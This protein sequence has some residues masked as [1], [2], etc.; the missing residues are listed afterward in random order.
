MKKIKYFF[1]ILQIAI[2]FSICKSQFILQPAFPGLVDFS[3]PVELVNAYDGTDR[4]FLVQQHGKIYVFSNSPSVST[5]KNFINLTSKVSQG[6]LS[7]LF[8]LAFHPD[9][10]NKRYFYVY[11]I[12]DSTATQTSKWLRVS[13]YTASSS[14]PDTALVSSELILLTEPVIGAGYHFGGKIAFGP[15]GYLYATCGDGPPN[16]GPSPAQDKT[17]LLGKIFRINVD[18]ASAG[19]SYSIPATNPFYGNTQGYREEIYAYGFRNL[20]KF[21][22]DYTTNNLWGGDVGQNLY[23]EIDLIENGKNYGWDKMEGFHCVPVYLCDTAGYGFTLPVYEYRHTGGQFAVM[24]GYVYR[25]SQ[26]PDLYG[27]YIYGDEISSKIWALTY[28][29]INPPANIQLLDTT[30]DLVSFGVDQNE[31]IYVLS[32]SATAG[33]IYKLVNNSIIT[34]SLRTAIEGFYNTENNQLNIRDTLNIYLRSSASPYS[35]I[36]S[37]KTVI[38]SLTNTGLCFFRNAP[39]GKYYLAINHRNTLETWSRIGGDSLRKGDIMSYDFTAD[40]ST[41]YG[42]NQVRKGNI[43][44]IYSGDINKDGIIDIVDQSL[45]ENDAFNY[46]SGYIATDLNGDGSADLTDQT[47]LDNNLYNF[48]VKITP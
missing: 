21:S 30:F 12:F 39:N 44:C 20:W 46:N 41:A 13:R 8:G 47:I 11:Y 42:N 38:D 34:L 7:G 28:N 35:I 15:D 4:L 2:T 32:Y 37:S 36:D 6:S 3:L 16:S 14:N 45:L 33:K 26:H 40:S 1:T 29:G 23:E 18:S 22:F 19:K 9:Y 5:K 25:G 48:V 24:G 27:K 31:E 43:F 17:N 10:E